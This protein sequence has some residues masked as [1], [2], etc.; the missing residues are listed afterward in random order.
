MDEQVRKPNP[1]LEPSSYPQVISKKIP[2]YEGFLKPQLIEIE[3]RGKVPSYEVDKAIEKYPFTIDI[4][5]IEDLK[6]KKRKLFHK[7]PEESYTK[8]VRTGQVHR[9]T[10]REGNTWFQYS[11][12]HKSS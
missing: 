5:A 7:I 12:K 9:F 1:L 4:P 2:K 10:E 3:L 8:A 6:E 11:N